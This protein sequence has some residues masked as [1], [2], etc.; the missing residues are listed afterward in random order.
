MQPE[1]VKCQALDDRAIILNC[2]LG[3]VPHAKY[4]LSGV[5]QKHKTP[6]EHDLDAVGLYKHRQLCYEISS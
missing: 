1:V 5:K 4:L 2:L 3:R 6:D